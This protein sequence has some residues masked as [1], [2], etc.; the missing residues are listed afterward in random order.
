M[1]ENQDGGDRSG[2]YRQEQGFYFAH[3]TS[4]WKESIYLMGGRITTPRL[5]QPGVFTHLTDLPGSREGATDL[6]P[7][8]LRKTR[9][10]SVC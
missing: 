5:S 9:S 6:R 10:E 8:Q 2:E 3:T 1:G 7:S 4:C